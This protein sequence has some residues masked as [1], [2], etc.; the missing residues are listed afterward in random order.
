MFPPFLPATCWVQ[1][2]GVEVL[3]HAIKACQ[4]SIDSHKGKLAVKEA[5]RAVSGCGFFGAL[6]FV[7]LFVIL[8]LRLPLLPSRDPTKKLLRRTDKRGMVCRVSGQRRR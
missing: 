8:S 3:G 5:P 4:V 1:G 6:F 7:M 2:L